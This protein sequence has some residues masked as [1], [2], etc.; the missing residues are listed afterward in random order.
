MK[1][2]IFAFILTMGL[3]LSLLTACG[4]EKKEIYLTADN[5]E[6]YFIITCNVSTRPTDD[7]FG[8]NEGWKTAN[9][10]VEVKKLKDVTLN[11]V[12]FDVI[13]EIESSDAMPAPE[14]LRTVSVRLPLDGNAYE[15]GSSGAMWFIKPTGYTVTYKNVRGS[16]TENK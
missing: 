5:L 6:E 13:F 14:G 16:V 10:T 8:E 9:Y 4:D 12:K 1:K 15:T 7:W 11:D 3:V 2:H